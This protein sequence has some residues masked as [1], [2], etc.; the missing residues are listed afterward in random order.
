MSEVQDRMDKLKRIDKGLVLVG[1]NVIGELISNW[2]KGKGGDNTQFKELTDEYA[3]RKASGKVKVGAGY[4]GGN[5][6]ANMTLTGKM[7]QGLTVKK[8]NSKAV[9][10]T[11]LTPE[12]PK[13]EGNQKERPNMMKLRKTFKNKQ[14]KILEKYISGKLA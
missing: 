3:E 6:I 12:K 2:T 5:P 7:Q 10:I 13:A 14:I 1:N 9:D 4:R 8:V 11:F